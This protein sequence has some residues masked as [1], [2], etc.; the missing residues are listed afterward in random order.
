M[1][2]VRVAGVSQVDGLQR[3]RVRRFWRYV[4]ARTAAHQVGARQL[5]GLGEDVAAEEVVRRAIFLDYDDYVLK[6]SVGLGD[7]ERRGEGEGE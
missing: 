4:F 6:W 1:A 2:V 3:D 5:A 7:G